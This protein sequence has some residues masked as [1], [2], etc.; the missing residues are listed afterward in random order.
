MQC[1][2]LLVASRTLEKGKG[3]G[4]WEDIGENCRNRG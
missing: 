4:D 2:C 3:S 1:T